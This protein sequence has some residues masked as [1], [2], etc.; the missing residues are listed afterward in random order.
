M[1]ERLCSP[2]DSNAFYVVREVDDTENRN[3]KSWKV[4][5]LAGIVSA[6]SWNS[7]AGGTGM[8]GGGTSTASLPYSEFEDLNEST[9]EESNLGKISKRSQSVKD[10]TAKYELD[11]TDRENQTIN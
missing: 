5:T 9:F 2:S 1:M 3:L 6:S 11:R 7:V 4:M 8:F 10:I